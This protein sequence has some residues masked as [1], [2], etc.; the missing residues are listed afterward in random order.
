ME[1][2]GV[3]SEEEGTG[4]NGVR[5]HIE[6]NHHGEGG[7]SEEVS[8]KN[9]RG[10]EESGREKDETEREQKMESRIRTDDFS[11]YRDPPGR[12][13]DTATLGIASRCCMLKHPERMPLPDTN[14]TDHAHDADADVPNAKAPDGM[15]LSEHT[16]KPMLGC[17][18]EERR[19]SSRHL[20]H[21]IDVTEDCDDPSLPLFAPSPL[22]PAVV[23]HTTSLLTAVN[24]P[25]RSCC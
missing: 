14:R 8:D 15:P 9:G 1:R 13:S 22:F 16:I 10:E 24:R 17:K 23:Y 18:V 5:D 4:G 7:V 21:R 3:S 12:K 25:S 19:G 2:E 11:S 6:H 20:F